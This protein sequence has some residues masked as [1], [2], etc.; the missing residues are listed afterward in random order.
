MDLN[1]LSASVFLSKKYDKCEDGTV[2]KTSY[3]SAYEF[4]SITE[5]VTTLDQFYAHLVEHAEH[6]HCLLK[7][8]LQR[9]LVSESRAGATSSAS[10]TQWVCLDIDGLPATHSIDKLMDMMGLGNVSYV[11]QWSASQNI[12]DSDHLR[13]H[14]FMLLD[15]PVAA[16]IL[17]QWLT[18]LNLTTPFLMEN[19]TLTKTNLSLRWG[20]DITSCQNDRLL[21]I[22][23]PLLNGIKNPLGRTPRYSVVN[24]K[25]QRLTLP[26]RISTVETNRA[27]AKAVIE[28]LRAKAN[29]PPR[30]Y[31]Y[32]TYKD[33][34]VLSKPDIGIVTGI[35]RERG[36][37]YLNLNG[38]DSWGYYHHENDPEI[39]H[40]FKDEPAYATKEL[41][42]EYYEEL[43]NQAK[44]ETSEKLSRAQLGYRLPKNEAEP[45]LLAFRDQSTGTYHHG[46]YWEETETLDLNVAKNEKQVR[47][48]CMQHDM[49]MGDY[50]PLW[51]IRF[52]PQDNVRVDVTNNYINTFERTEYM[53]NG[54]VRKNLAC[55]PT[56]FKLIH[57]VV[58]EEPGLTEHFINWLAFIIQERT[59][60]NT[61]W[62]LYGTEGTGKGVL[63]KHVLR[64][65][66]GYN[67]VSANRVDELE[68]SF[69]SFTKNKLLVFM[70]EVEIPRLRDPETILAKLRN[71]ITEE[72]ISLR[73]LYSSPVNVPNHMNLILASNR[74]NAVQLSR[75]DRR[76][77]VGRFQTKKLQLTA[78]E[79]E[80]IDSRTELQDFYD[81]LLSLIVDVH[82]AQTPMNTQERDDLIAITSS[83]ADDLANALKDGS[84]SYLISMLPTDDMYQTNA[85]SM[86]RV[87]NYRLVLFRWL[88]RTRPNGRCNV[89][90]DELRVLFE[91]AVGDMP[92]GPNKFTK[93][94]AHR[95]IRIEDVSIDMK[96]L[97]GFQVEFKD[98]DQFET[99]L[100][101]HFS[102]LNKTITKAKT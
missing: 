40:N 2:Q 38:G 41:L 49:P 98:V 54:T 99:Y 67:Q 80:I 12:T 11:L 53:R 48:F 90:R 64:P 20:L 25:H 35:K 32:R 18:Q 83:S 56:I 10:T 6:G 91:Y 77:N 73:A 70:D 9:P 95:H 71:L 63:F 28:Q 61:A 50:I 42:P 31:T 14:V 27:A 66:L 24:K 74:P 96:T 79:N 62:L 47:D 68:G 7:G 30:K 34:E 5:N 88:K 4:T 72:T 13:C 36:F 101:E 29:L 100:N 86:N 52:D 76:Y 39:I 82:A 69:N 37:V 51:D 85:L 33:T 16:P 65:L 46:K 43:K 89:A 3:P 17:K 15:R 22:A 102:V 94:L 23:K 60:T 45:V 87:E 59:R 55:P 8:D 92:D 97:R 81:Y 44:R 1:F 78:A 93:Y 19:L 26:E 21:Y 58:G 75:N 57:H 84:M